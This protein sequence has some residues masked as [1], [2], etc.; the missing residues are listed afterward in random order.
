[1]VE[2]T[3]TSW[4]IWVVWIFHISALIGISM[5]FETW[6]VSKT[7]INLLISS[8]LLFLVF[9]VDTAKKGIL[10]A[11]LW[12]FGM[13]AE[14]LGVSYGILFG[15]YSYGDN[16]GPKWNG[17]PFLIGINWALLSFITARIAQYISSNGIIQVIFA[18]FLM[19]VLDWF[20]EQSAP[21]F[22]FWE[23]DQGIVPL[24]N[25][26]CWLGLALIFQLAIQRMKITGDL[27]F[28]AHLYAAQLVFFLFFYLWF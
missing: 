1:M 18:A 27:R 13:L 17:V 5:G 11:A 25:Y 2:K 26:V 9:P 19:L 4:A 22:D 24:S 3:N 10:F 16:L 12:F 28:S 23:F 20:M 21:R 14:W 7:P 8:F 6:F 15:S